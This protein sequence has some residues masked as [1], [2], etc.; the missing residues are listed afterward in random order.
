MKWSTPVDIK[1]STEKIYP[2]DR[3]FSIGS[4]FST[5]M[6]GLLGEGQIQTL[7][8]PFGTLFNPYSIAKA[9]ERIH[10]AKYYS[11]EDLIGY[12][13]KVI[14]LDHHSSYSS[15]FAHLS[16]EKINHDMDTAL[17]FLREAK[18]VLIT[19]GSA[20]IYEFLPKGVLVA[21][22]HK[23]P[24]KFF[25]KRLLTREEIALSLERTTGLIKDLCPKGVKI[26]LSLSPVRHTKDG[27][28]EN[29]RSKALL[30]SEIHE[31][32][33]R[34]EEVEYL[35]AYE[36]VLDELRDYR[37]YKEDLVHPSPQAVGYIFEKFGKAYFSTETKEFIEENFKI[38]KALAHRAFDSSSKEF[39]TF[40]KTLL[41]RIEVQRAKVKHSIFKEV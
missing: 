41:A 32:C 1:E 2:S 11:E 15:R 28:V 20:Y 21:N 14:S 35:P 38:N 33:E 36:I 16:L 24:S 12:R 31:A 34:F 30:L 37:F 23:L 17:N 6:S 3:V 9:I 8:N 39:E 4:C 40:R 26:L 7:S 27:M 22:C 19:L 5:E 18:W 10:G 13:E 25:S 29:Q